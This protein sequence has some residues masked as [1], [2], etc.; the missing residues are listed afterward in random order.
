MKDVGG[1]TSRA[2]RRVVE[3]EMPWEARGIDWKEDSQAS[4]L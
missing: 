1:V 2:T 4:A 3:M